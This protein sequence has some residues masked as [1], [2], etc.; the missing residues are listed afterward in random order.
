MN[1]IRRLQL[2][3]LQL[4]SQLRFLQ[5]S[6]QPLPESLTYCLKK[7]AVHRLW[8]QSA[9][10]AS[11]VPWQRNLLQT[12]PR[13][14]RAVGDAAA[15]LSWVGEG[16]ALKAG[17]WMQIS[18][19]HFS[20]GLN[21][22]HIASP[23]DVT[24]DQLQQLMSSLQPLLALSGFDLQRSTQGNWY[25]W[26]AAVLD[27]H[28]TNLN[29]TVSTRSYDILPTG[30][31]APPVRRLLTEVQML[32]NQHPINQQREAHGL[33][34]LNAAWINGAGSPPVATSSTLQR[35]MSDQPYVLGL[36]DQLNVTCWPVP[37][38]VDELLAVREDDQVLVLAD[39]VASF[40]RQW[41][42]PLLRAS[43]RG[44]VGEF[45]LYLEHL[46]LSLS[47]GRWRQLRRSMSAANSVAELLS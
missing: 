12:L 33:A 26:C 32:L 35:I 10:I 27:V 41:L 34:P 17:T 47:G 22:V 15:A 39:E 37:R 36:C 43:V 45:H 1:T 16:G 28:T 2:I 29:A 13:E 42:Q 19:V 20:A 30:T 25:L 46:K 44:Y 23:T 5:A 7:A 11:L 38:S 40:D 21:D 6:G 31:D 14:L 3:P 4:L 18:L 9:D 8:D 24:D